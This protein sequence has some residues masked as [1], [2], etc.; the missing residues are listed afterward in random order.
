MS[1]QDKKRAKLVDVARHAGVSPGTVSNALHNTRFVEPETRRRIEEAIQALNYTPNIRARQL[2]TG[3]TNTIALLS[4]LPL[5]IASG[6]SKLG[7][8]MEVAL[9]AAIMAL[10]KQH[11]L[12]LIPPGENPLDRVSFDAAILIEPAENDPQ[13]SALERAGI[14]C[15]TIGR[16]PGTRTPAPWVDLHSAATAGLLLAHLQAAGTSKC[17]LFVGNIRRTSTLETEAAYRRWCEGRQ[18]PIIYYLNESEG[19]TAGYQAAHQLL[20]DDPEVDGVLVL[21]DTFASGAVRAFHETKTAIPER[22]RLVTRYDG[23]RARE[24]QPQMTAMNMHLDEVARQAVTLL[25]EVLAGDSVEK[26]SGLMPELL[27]RK[28]TQR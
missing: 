13:L 10:E 15:V 4:S 16:T 12:I 18:L 24:S 28:S 21:V 8:M 6:A 5:T 20:Q 25:F 26:S 19:E 27:V 14:P 3:K 17:A 7:F 1:A 9:T 2:R 11:A 23:I 22:M